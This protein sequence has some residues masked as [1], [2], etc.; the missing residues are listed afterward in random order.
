[1]VGARFCKRAATGTRCGAMVGMSK[2]FGVVFLV[3]GAALLYYGWR[4][5][6]AA[7]LDAGVD[8]VAEIARA[9]S[10]WLFALGA[11]TALWGLYALARRNVL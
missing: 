4:E 8:A 2:L 1:M 5:H 6:E 10:I 11:M 7:T 3:I 9:R